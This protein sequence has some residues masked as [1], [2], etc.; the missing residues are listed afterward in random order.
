MQQEVESTLGKLF[1]AHKLFISVANKMDG[2]VLMTA[3]YSA[4]TLLHLVNNEVDR[5]NEERD[6]LIKFFG[7]ERA[8]TEQEQEQTGSLKV[9]QV[10]D[11]HWTEYTKKMKEL[12]NVPVKLKSGP[13]NPAWFDPKPC[14]TCGSSGINVTALELGALMGANLLTMPKAEEP[15]D[16]TDS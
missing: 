13:L 16:E 4:G 12:R 3:K 14:K 8:A 2:K 10:K 7:F 1:D 15:K 11:E 6:T 5:F 9:W